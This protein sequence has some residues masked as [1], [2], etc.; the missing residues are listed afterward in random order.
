M[1]YVDTLMPCIPNCRWKWSTSAHLYAD[2][3]EELH[4]F[5]ARL[6]LK[7]AWFQDRHGR[8][9]SH[10]DV[11]EGKRRLAITLGAVEQSLKQSGTRSL[12]LLR[13]HAAKGDSDG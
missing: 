11:T 8:G 7:R 1:V 6:G 3:L 4:A 12:A 10:Y 9:L 2:T 13:A 5:A